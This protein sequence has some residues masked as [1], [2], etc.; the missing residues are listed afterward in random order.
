MSPRSSKKKSRSDGA[1][2]VLDIYVGLLLFS[3]GALIMGIVF[4]HFQ[5]SAYL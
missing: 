1:Q 2:P 4:L 3:V 5:L